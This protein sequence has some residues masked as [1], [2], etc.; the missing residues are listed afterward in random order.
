M[1]SSADALSY[2]PYSIAEAL[3]WAAS[4]PPWTAGATLANEVRRLQGQIGVAQS[5]IDVIAE[6]QR[7]LVWK[8]NEACAHLYALIGYVANFGSFLNYPHLDDARQ[9]WNDA[10]CAM[11]AVTPTSPPETNGTNR[12]LADVRAAKPVA[13]M[14]LE[15]FTALPGKIIETLPPRPTPLTALL[16]LNRIVRRA[17]VDLLEASC[18][19]EDYR[20]ADDL[21][22]EL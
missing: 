15:E 3:V 17:C 9:A 22:V 20:L 11:R 18:D 16:E 21:G 13:E 1:T 14:T 12:L 6:Q 19:A 10:V 8:C 2:G 5:T 4:L 7:E